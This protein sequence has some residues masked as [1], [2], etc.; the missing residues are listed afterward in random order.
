MI[1]ILL[2]VLLALAALSYSWTF[3]PLGRLDYKAALISKLASLQRG[4]TEL[5][6]QARAKAN[7]ATERMLGKL[8][9]A[10]LERQEDR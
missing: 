3:T 6:P 1:A 4:A 9:P 10:P 8:E 5:T 7:K 2:L